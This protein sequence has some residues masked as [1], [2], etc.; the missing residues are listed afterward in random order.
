MAAT[1]TVLNIETA[2]NIK[3]AFDSTTPQAIATMATADNSTSMAFLIKLHKL[4]QIT[5]HKNKDE[6][7][8][9]QGWSGNNFETL[10]IPKTDTKLHY[11]I[12]TDKVGRKTL[13]IVK[14]PPSLSEDQ[15]KL[16]NK[17]VNVGELH[18]KNSQLDYF[19]DS[20]YEVIPNDDS[21][22]ENRAQSILNLIESPILD[23]TKFRFSDSLHSERH[24]FYTALRN[25]NK[26]SEKEA[27]EKVL[28]AGGVDKTKAEKDIASG[29]FTKESFAPAPNSPNSQTN[30]ASAAAE[31]VPSPSVVSKRMAE[32]VLDAT[33]TVEQN[34]GRH[35][36]LVLPNTADE[37]VAKTKLN[38]PVQ[39]DLTLDLDVI[40][41]ANQQPQPNHTASAS[42]PATIFS[43]QG[44]QATQNPLAI[45]EAP[46]LDAITDALEQNVTGKPNTTNNGCCNIL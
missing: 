5:L 11:I 46:D 20:P 18:F 1:T 21:Y 27:L 19:T 15:S 41:A 6:L 14:Q 33:T 37:A 34:N 2:A 4:Q 25:N 29:A 17:I 26:Y 7:Y 16:E 32:L 39:P 12:Q 44:M 30:F 45:T 36:P 13:H 9:L 43:S 28:I 31:T 42:P 10:S 40:A 8:S 38:A 22:L 35:Q 23:I 3:T 24:A